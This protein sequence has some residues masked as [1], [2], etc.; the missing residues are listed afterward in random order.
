MTPGSNCSGL[1]NRITEAG[2]CTEFLQWR[3]FV[4][5]VRLIEQMERLWENQLSGNPY[6]IAVSETTR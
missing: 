3:T 4:T 5:A 6:S 1:R 2:C